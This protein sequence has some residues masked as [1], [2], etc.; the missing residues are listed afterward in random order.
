MDNR[1]EQEG[2][3]G[4]VKDTGLGSTGFKYLGDKKRCSAGSWVYI[5]E[6]Q[7]RGLG[8]FQVHI[9]SEQSLESRQTPQEAH[10]E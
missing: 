7:E 6:F 9:H 5:S 2:K 10:I 1:E 8:Q 3:E 4:K